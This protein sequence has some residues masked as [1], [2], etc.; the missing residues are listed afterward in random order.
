MDKQFLLPGEYACT[1]KP[2]IL[3]TV[4]GSCVSVCLYNTQN[5]MAAMNHFIYPEVK[6]GSSEKDIGRHGATAIDQIV[7]TL[8][9]FDPNPRHYKAQIFGGAHVINSLNSSFSIGDR[10]VALAEEYLREYR[11]PIIRKETGGNNGFKIAMN[12]ETN[13]VDVSSIQKTKSSYLHEKDKP[14][15]TASGLKKYKVLV[16]DDSPLVCKILT[17]VI[18]SFDEFEVIGNALNAYDARDMLVNLGP[19]LMTLDIIMPKMDGITFMKKVS[20][21]FPMPVVICSTIAKENS[22]IFKQAKDAGAAEVVDKDKLDLYSNTD[23][24][25]QMLLPKL[26]SALRQFSPNKLGR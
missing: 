19:D 23:N 17:Q 18:N 3:S 24:V 26:K 12:T 1:K 20:Q 16:V 10:N 25:K 9:N 8:F 7:K 13:L 11:I 5:K 14:A 4:L 22:P 15:T 6:D 21:Y 2:T